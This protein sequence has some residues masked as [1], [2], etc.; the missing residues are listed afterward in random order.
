MQ[1]MKI[2][3]FTLVSL[4]LISSCGGGGGGGGSTSD[5]TPSASLPI[6]NSFSSN[7]SSA[8][9][10]DSITI[11]WSSSNTTSC[12]ASGDLDEWQ[13]S[14]ITNGSKDITL[15]T[16]GT[17]K[18]VLTCSNSIGRTDSK[19]ISIEV[20]SNNILNPEITSFTLSSNTIAVDKTITVT[21]SSENASTCSAS[22]NLNSW[23][24]SVNTNDSIN[25]LMTSIGSYELILICSNED[26]SIS[27][28]EKLLLEVTES[29]TPTDPYA[30]DKDSY[31]KLPNND[32]G[33]S[34][35]WIEEFDNNKLDTDIFSYQVGN[36][37]FSGGNWVGG[38]GNNEE[39]YYTSCDPTYSKQCNS[40]NNTTENTFIENGFL[41]IQPIYWNPEYPSATNGQSPFLDPYNQRP[42]L[43]T[44]GKL[45][46]SDKKI[47]NPGSEVTVCF[48]VPEGSGHWPAF[49]MLPQGFMD[50][51][52]FWPRD[53]EIDL[54][55][56]MKTNQD[57]QIQ[58]TVHY[59]NTIDD[60]TYIYGIETVPQNVNF[61]DK[62]HSITFK[63][64]N[65]KLEFYL[66]MHD[67]PFHSLDRSTSRSFMND[68]T[69]WPFNESFYLIMNVAV[70]G[71]LGGFIDDSKYCQDAECSN[72]PDPD[73][74]R[75]LIDYIE[76]KSIN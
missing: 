51:E 11:S 19:N 34:N 24:G 69:Y 33:S 5:N 31:C 20:I 28:Q 48:K 17:F 53:G 10:N 45:I 27:D 6:I 25:I 9:T 12:N 42:F 55:E 16:S 47:I 75:L 63:W 15:S 21:W 67:E 71:D 26:Q 58:S 44:S 18:L 38:W 4:I 62:F 66:D 72:L 3:I 52:K 14:V 41:K 13:G 46:T 40:L 64:V 59:G 32:D 65:N 76:V 43:Y 54:M 73:R 57:N 7:L 49:W 74:G 1:N 39:Q 23:Q 2:R 50:D 8:N 22:G 61:V 36:G 37:F 29:D 56:H 30:V 35:Y 70:G 68:S 60:H